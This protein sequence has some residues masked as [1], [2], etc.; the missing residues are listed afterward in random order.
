MIGRGVWGLLALAFALGLSWSATA[1]PDAVRIPPLV[2]RGDTG[3]P[4]ALFR[5]GRHTHVSCLGCH[6]TLFPQRREGFTHADMEGGRLCVACH[7]GGG[8]FAIAEVP[9]ERCHAPM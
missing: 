7:D 9:C 3:P 5:H 8:A 2:S 4:P 6:P 1:M